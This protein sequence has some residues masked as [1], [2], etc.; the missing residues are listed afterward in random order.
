MTL[1]ERERWRAALIVLPMV[2]LAA[3]V[4]PH[5]GQVA[6]LAI[7]VGGGALIAVIALGIV[8]TYTGSGT[9]NFATGAVAMY[10]AYVF[11][12]LRTDG[13]LFLPPLPNPLALIEHVAGWFGATI[14]L[15][16]IPT[17]I[18]FAAPRSTVKLGVAIKSPA[19]SIP[20]ALLI[21]GA[22]CLCIGAL[23]YLLIFRPLRHAPPL[24]KVVASVGLL[25]LFQSTVIIRFGSDAQAVAPLLGTATTRI[26]LVG[27]DVPR[28]QLIL[29]GIVI[30]LAVSTWAVY[31]FTRVGLAMRAAAEN[32]KGAML[33]GHSPSM[34]GATSWI[35]STVVVGLLGVLAAPINRSIDPSSTSLLIVPALAATLIGKFSSIGLTVAAA[36]A[37]GMTE[38]WLRGISTASW[39]P[40]TQGGLAIPGITDALPFV[41][42][43]LVLVVRGRSLP[44]R[45]SL[46]TI[47][48]PFAPRPS[49]V[50][51]KAV[52]LSVIA[53]VLLFTTGPTWRLGLI[54]TM[55]GITI[56]LS[57]VIVTGYLGQISLVQMGVA[58]L[59]GFAL[60][61]FAD[62]LGVPFPIAPLLG[63]AVAV[64]AG[65]LT[66]L[67]ALRIRGVQLAVVT[68]AGAV[69]IE[70]FVFSNPDWMN[71]GQVSVGSPRLFGLH[72][73]PLDF[74]S[75]GDGK[76]PDVF[77]GLFCLIVVVAV[78]LLAVKLRR[79]SIGRHML[80]VRANERAAAAAGVSVAR[81]KI[82]GFG[83][84]A[85]VAGLGGALSAY[86][87]GGVTGSYFDEFASLAFLAAAYLGGISSVTGAVL[88]GLMVTQ[89]LISV[90]FTQ[91]FHVSDQYTL[92]VGAVGL[93]IA[94]VRAPEGMAGEL[95]HRGAALAALVR[96]RRGR[97][98]V[99]EQVVVEASPRA[100]AMSAPKA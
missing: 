96:G 98:A 8:L 21:T 19:M 88:G 53:A 16:D 38:S 14:H 18:R 13:R 63:A 51:I 9:I 33:L 10:A 31:R 12:S 87:F 43:I 42:I 54:N 71:S 86:R 4:L 26:P 68:F 61:K 79:S 72:F 24:A 85:F 100:A 25:I 48:M 95:R 17:G 82:V 92:F 7:G 55:V 57:F 15:P 52:A 78:T 59:S 34:L 3:V 46:E 89:G 50:A 20:V 30:G 36:F 69:V 11:E 67:P 62:G 39:F 2:A 44:V 66:A 99:P 76:L 97:D 58:G 75:V 23:T 93:I 41:V 45:G 60:S 94:A 70:N 40:K 81:T 49:N 84:A 29:A 6:A 83:I 27:V 37:L 32:E 28:D 77:F 73:G 90:A 5:K 80:A 64:L 74:H 1:R 35:A 91:W 56:C 22:V 47:R 65:V